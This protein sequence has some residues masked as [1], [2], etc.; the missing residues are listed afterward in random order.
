MASQIYAVPVNSAQSSHGLTH[1]HWLLLT[2]ALALI[3]AIIP[4]A[5]A[6]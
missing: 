6:G 3:L 5:A 1:A 2:A 4:R